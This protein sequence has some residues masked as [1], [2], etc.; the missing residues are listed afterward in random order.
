MA[1]FF[2]PYSPENKG[3]QTLFDTVQK[4]TPTMWMWGMTLA[5]FI[6]SACRRLILKAS[7]HKSHALS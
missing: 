2:T 5:I 7:A 1:C 3:K 4:K 6:L